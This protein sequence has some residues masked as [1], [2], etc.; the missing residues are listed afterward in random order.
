MSVLSLARESRPWRR[1]GV[2]EAWP[3]GKR[4]HGHDASPRS[5]ENGGIAFR[6]C[7]PSSSSRYSEPPLATADDLSPTRPPGLL[8]RLA[9]L[10]YDLILLFGMLLLAATLVIIPASA[11]TGSEIRLEGWPRL[12]FQLYLL[13]VGYG[14]FAY[15]WRHGGQTLG[16]RAWRFGLVRA[17][18]QPLTGSDVRRR[19]LWSTLIPAPLGIFWVP[20]DREGLAPHDRLSA[21]RPRLLPPKAR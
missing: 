1:E 6:P 12:L 11:L 16:M 4:P 18:G 7:R 21:T 17:D 13:L 15:F 10:L 5:W 20:F 8:R 2:G 3:R 19:L 9:A 14:F